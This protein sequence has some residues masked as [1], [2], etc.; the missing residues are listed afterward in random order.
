MYAKSALI[1]YVMLMLS[2]GNLSAQV[3]VEDYER[4]YNLSALASDKVFHSDIRPV[5]IASRYFLYENITP[6][7]NV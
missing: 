7:G 1:I 4:A 6:E 2:I 5:W 3:T